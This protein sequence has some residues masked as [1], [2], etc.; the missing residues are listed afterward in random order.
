MPDPDI[1]AQFI[2]RSAEV[3]R[4]VYDIVAQLDGSISAEHGLD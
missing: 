1:N 4:I 2:A 3:N